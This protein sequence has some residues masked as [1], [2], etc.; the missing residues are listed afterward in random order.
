M[1]LFYH[2]AQGKIAVPDVYLQKRNLETIG[3]L[4]VTD[5]TV[6]E[7]LNDLNAI[8]FQVPRFLQGKE[9][10]CYEAL[11]TLQLIDLPPHGHFSISV[12]ISSDGSEEKRV[13][14]TS[15]ETELDSRYLD[16]FQANTFEEGDETDGDGNYIRS[17][18]FDES[19]KEHSILHRALSGT[20]WQIKMGGASEEYAKLCGRY[21]TYDLNRQSVRSFLCDLQEEYDL[22]FSYGKEERI[23]TCYLL[24]DY[25][26]DTGI[27]AS[28]ENLNQQIQ[29]QADEDSIVTALKISGG[30]GIYTEDVIPSPSGQLI[31]LDYFLNTR[32]M[33]QDTIDAWN[34]YS[35]FYEAASKTYGEKLLLWE[36]KNTLLNEYLHSV[37]QSQTKE[38]DGTLTEL[39]QMSRNEL[40]S[41]FSWKSYDGSVPAE[42]RFNYGQAY[43][44]AIYDAY[45]EA[46]SARIQTEQTA[47]PLYEQMLVIL[48]TSRAALEQ[49][50]TQI[51]ALTA[52]ISALN[53]EKAELRQSCD[54]KTRLREYFSSLGLTGDELDNKVF[55]SFREL[56]SFI[57]E[58]E[59][60]NDNYFATDLDSY[61]DRME[62][63]RELIAQA[64]KEL[65]KNC[66]PHVTWD[67]KISNP[68][69]RKEFDF[70]R[71]TLDIGNFMTLEMHE[72][73]AE[74]IRIIGAE[75]PYD[76]PEEL[77][78]TFSDQVESDSDMDDIG[79]QIGSATSAAASLQSIAAQKDNYDSAYQFVQEMI[80]H[81]LNAALSGI[82]NDDNQ[83]ITIDRYGL[84]GRARKTAGDFEPEQILIQKN[85]IL[86]TDDYWKTIRS[87]LGKIEV[88]HTDGSVTYQYGLIAD[89]VL[90]DDLYALGASI[91]QWIIDADALRSPHFRKS[92][93]NTKILEGTY[94]GADGSILTP[95]LQLIPGSGL[96]IDV[97]SFHLNA[98]GSSGG[99]TLE[100]YL[101]NI[102]D[103][104]VEEAKKD[105]ENICSH[106]SENGKIICSHAQA[107]GCIRLE[108]VSGSSTQEY[109]PAPE[110][111]CAIRSIGDSGFL[112]FI[113]S[114]SENMA[115]ETGL[116]QK[117]H[118]PLSSPLRS[119]GDTC[120]EILEQDGELGILQRIDSI[121]LTGEENFTY[122]NGRFCLP[123][124]TSAS[125]SGGCLSNYYT[126]V[127]EETASDAS[128]YLSDVLSPEAESC[129]VFQ[130][131]R[132]SSTED[133]QAWLAQC[134]ADGN[135]LVVNYVLESPA[136]H[137]FPKEDR[138]SLSHI[139]S[140]QAPVL[141][142]FEEIFPVHFQASFK[143][144]SYYETYKL[145]E[146]FYQMENTLTTSFREGILNENQS[147]ILSQQLNFL[148]TEKTRIDQEYSALS[149]KNNLTDAAKQTLGTVKEEYDTA[150]ETLTAAILAASQ[151]S[152]IT[153]VEKQQVDQAYS[154]YQEALKN[155][156]AAYQSYLAEDI[157]ELLKNNA[158]ASMAS[159]I[160]ELESTLNLK[161][162]EIESGRLNLDVIDEKYKNELYKGEPFGTTYDSLYRQLITA[163]PESSGEGYFNS[164][165][166]LISKFSESY[167][168]DPRN[169]G[170]EDDFS[171]IW[172]Q[173]N[174][175]LSVL[176]QYTEVR[177]AFSSYIQ[178][179]T[180]QI[181]SNDIATIRRTMEF[182][183]K[184][185]SFILP[186]HA[187]ANNPVVLTIS[188]DAIIFSKNPIWTSDTTG[189]TEEELKER[190][191]NGD[192]CSYFTSS[193]LQVSKSDFENSLISDT[194]QIGN[195]IWEKRLS[196][197]ESGASVEHLTLSYKSS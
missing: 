104:A 197:D 95:N 171:E 92:E 58:D 142:Y 190:I 63:T 60:S 111:P 54:V 3:R 24:S 48:D 35:A 65:K 158:N 160:S 51:N 167:Q 22:L 139:E 103:E 149:N 67:C 183:E 11:E 59:Y 180:N 8:S 97:D 131:S 44:Q 72:G 13:S 99:I 122:Q 68:A 110:S 53:Q 41:T 15:W 55:S 189:F 90:V 33:N 6:T 119:V 27:Y 166:S 57:R 4:F 188:A 117:I 80:Q 76:K 194:L 134:R 82:Y 12:E 153:P 91:G 109:P 96:T 140:F 161:K 154:A 165:L 115:S 85:K 56:Q 94:L 37:P 102:K 32:Y 143:T 116:V 78:L 172:Q 100:Q 120:D 124:Q 30:D 7:H 173:Y 186:S 45:D 47:D 157:T 184:H 43:L 74:K 69:L 70:A 81:G 101:E 155:F 178:S 89:T 162:E 148:G 128:V 185:I 64:E 46:K 5:L 177:Q 107:G 137:I 83:E 146:S 105:T 10:P 40:T 86:F 152:L 132:F 156:T 125:L 114:A 169:P 141:L 25:G 126:G 150:Y 192:I 121:V 16:S 174:K 175:Y 39:N 29:I 42:K 66:R 159:K 151:D 49:R 34:S 84:W 50:K 193:S 62:I 145:Q 75:I 52:E 144:K 26:R 164:I 79:R 136:F 71:E 147:Q 21:P 179:Q 38:E 9:N 77:H 93:D 88:K 196:A 176:N 73:Y 130:D 187:D 1:S 23:I 182:D 14:G 61:A 163:G 118:L 181:L 20:G 28:F 108:F 106:T 123:L 168:Q 195:Y 36:D 2:D 138:D 129:L 135:P 87:V 127:S 133:F 112:D 98:G 17:H 19:D 18:L 113:C 31:C 191:K 170:L